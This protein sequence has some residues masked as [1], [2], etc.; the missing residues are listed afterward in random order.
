MNAEGTA[1]ESVALTNY[2]SGY[3]ADP[4]VTFTGGGMTIAPT[5]SFNY[6]TGNL[7]N[8]NVITADLGTIL[9]LE[10]GSKN[11]NI[12]EDG[13]TLTYIQS[14]NPIE[15]SISYYFSLDGADPIF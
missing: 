3:I 8:Q 15:E 9:P 6:E 12:L 1:V 4:T 11:W 7:N 5:V 2:G 14:Y 10:N 13:Q